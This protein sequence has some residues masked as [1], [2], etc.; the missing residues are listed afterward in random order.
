MSYSTVALVSTCPF[1]FVGTCHNP[2]LQSKFESILLCLCVWNLTSLG[3]AILLILWITFFSKNFVVKLF[4]PIVASCATEIFRCWTFT[5]TPFP[6][7]FG[8]NA[9]LQWR[10]YS[11]PIWNSTMY[12]LSYSFTSVLWWFAVCSETRRPLEPLCGALHCIQCTK[13][14]FILIGNCIRW[15]YLSWFSFVLCWNF[16]PKLLTLLVAVLWFIFILVVTEGIASGIWNLSSIT[17]HS[18][19]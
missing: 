4:Q 17:V 3:I 6:L 2:L 11:S 18:D 9:L 12:L 16:P 1:P 19:F 5:I 10:D 14:H 13:H 8:C 15:L 7:V